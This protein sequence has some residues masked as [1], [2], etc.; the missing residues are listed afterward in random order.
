M[1]L[2]RVK[3]VF[4]ILLSIS[5][6]ACGGGG[7]GG[8]GTSSVAPPSN[9]QYSSPPAYVVNQAITALTP[10]V[11][12]QVTSYTV[13]PALPVGLSISA[14]TG[15]IS[16]TPTTATPQASYVVT[17][18]NS[19]GS[20]TATVS[21]T[22]KVA[23]PTIAYQSPRYSYTANVP[24]TT[25]TPTIGGGATTGWSINPSLPAGLSFDTTNGSI[26]GTPTAASAS[27]NYTVTA[28]NSGG[29]VNASLTI[30]VAAAPLYD[31]VHATQVVTMRAT[32]TR[33]VSIDAVG[34]WVLQNYSTG[35]TV[36]R[37]DFPQ[38]SWCASAPVFA[39]GY[40]PVD[41]AA[42]V[43]IDPVSTGVE[44][45]SSNDGSLLGTA[46]G[47]FSWY[48]LASDGS[49]LCTGNKNGLTVWSTSGQATFTHSGD[50]ST[51]VVFCAP[52]QV[53][54][55]LG[56]AGQ[57]V[58]EAVTVPGGVD[59]VGSSFQGRFQTWFADGSGFLSSLGTAVWVYS[60]SAVQED[61]LQVTQATSP[62][63][64]GG[65]GN[66]FW[67]CGGQY[68]YQVGSSAS[69]A[70]SY[71]S[72][73]TGG[74]TYSAPMLIGVAG[75]SNGNVGVLDLS[76][77]TITQ[78]TCQIGT[79]SVSD[80]AWVPGQ[81]CLVGSTRGVILDDASSSTQPR[82]LS[83]GQVFSVA[84]GTAYVSFATASGNIYTFDASTNALVST[85]NFPA[86]HLSMSSA[87]NVLAALADAPVLGTG[88][89]D[90]TLNV[91]SLPSGSVIGTF[92]SS[93]KIT[94]MS[95]SGSGT[96]LSLTSISTNG[97]CDAETVLV[98][99]GAPTWCDTT[100][101]AGA[102][103]VSPDGQLVASTVDTMGQLGGPAWIT[104]LFNGGV[105]A[106]AITGESIGWLDDTRLFVNNFIQQKYSTTYNGVTIYSPTGTVVSNLA[107]P[108]M[109]KIQPVTSD[110]LYSPDLNSLY[111]LTSAAAT[112]MSADAVTYTT[113]TES[114]AVAGPEVVFASGAYVLAQPY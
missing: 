79:L 51:S 52:G 83:D 70:Y 66:W 30:S 74:T 56:P 32:A 41:V 93:L 76:G 37:G 7:G 96:T 49:Y 48:Y 47:Q 2:Q 1:I 57:S 61:L 113:L 98:S 36:V 68:V 112:W 25:I 109:R 50:Y 53:L 44:I 73:C 89:P 13:S 71:G 20:T 26:S 46:V 38:C 63:K 23:A 108:Q 111:S 90:T 11:T 107:L 58:I 42:G 15:V 80:F 65:A 8:G 72:G 9:L 27:V 95:L 82:Y 39:P 21:I 10:T 60:D 5:L 33:V 67:I 81:S 91:Y 64:L 87:G 78:S 100:G 6:A 94:S 12:G 16:G 24:A 45:R 28:T 4:F 18:A 101:T 59:S 102:L 92:P 97:G 62:G 114:G 43:M 17:A 99:G 110:T 85:I 55:A 75:T 103:Q 31:L 106:T 34:H 22:V 69:P 104:N 105:L 40:Y 88:T 54:A 77:A 84:G 29:Q 86:G 19:G 35:A 14:S 3:S